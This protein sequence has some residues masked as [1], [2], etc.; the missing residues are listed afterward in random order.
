MIGIIRRGLHHATPFCLP[1]RHLRLVAQASP[2][3]DQEPMLEDQAGEPESAPNTGWRSVRA[4]AVGGKTRALGWS[5]NLSS[6]AA[7]C[8]PADP[9]GFNDACENPALSRPSRRYRGGWA[10]Y[11]IEKYRR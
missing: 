5:V 3:P 1:C 8:Q 4:I 2:R 9:C 10:S 6:A 7:F 11:S